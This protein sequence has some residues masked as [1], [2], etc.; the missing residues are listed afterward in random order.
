M[1]SVFSASNT[2]T[3]LGSN[4]TLSLGDT[5]LGD[6]AGAVG[7]LYAYNSSAF[8]PSTGWRR[9]N[10]GSYVDIASLTTQEILAL[11]SKVVKRFEGTTI[12]SHD[13]SDRLN[14]DSAF[15]IQ[16]RGTYTA[17]TDEYQGEWFKIARETTTTNIDTPIDEVAT[18]LNATNIFD[19]SGMYGN[20]GSGSVGNMPIDLENESIGP[21][22]QTSSGG[23]ING[24]MNVTGASTLQS[25][26]SV[27]GNS[28][29]ATTSVGEFTTTDRVNVTLNEIQG[30]PGGSEDLNIRNHFNF[31]SWEEG[32][33]NGTYTITLPS[34][35]QGVILRFKTDG[36]ISNSKDITLQ[37]QSG[38]RIDA[39][40]TYTMDR[41]YDGITLLG[42]MADTGNN[43]YIIQKKEK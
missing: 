38:E 5:R 17:N 28:T 14:F 8:V 43:W 11:Q 6:G 13:F 3:S 7:S 27:T 21:F 9:G 26:L 36:S 41:G 22:E 12:Q 20:I 29:L 19:F 32:A 4:I 40:A 15:W 10:S 1:S 18:D 33:G 24:T 37:P 42:R 16:M 39:E 25:T 30:N 31:I 2:S 34:V 35:E 23:E